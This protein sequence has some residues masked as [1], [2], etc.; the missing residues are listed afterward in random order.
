MRIRP[1]TAPR[2]NAPQGR[3]MVKH[4]AAALG[5]TGCGG[6]GK[7]LRPMRFTFI[8]AADLHVDSPLA[9]LGAK[10]RAVA[11]RFAHAGRK[12]VENL[13]AR[14]LE[15]KAAFLIIAGDLFDGDWRD[16]S[17]GHFLARALGPLHRADIPVFIQRGNH[18][19]ASKIA[20][21][22]PFAPSVR[23]F[24]DAAPQTFLL[25]H[26]GVALHGRSFG[27]RELP[28]DFV[29]T[30]P[31]AQAH[32]LNIGVLHTSLSGDRGHDPYAPASIADLRA[33]GYDYWAL[34]HVHAG[35]ILD[36]DPWVV[37]PGNLQGR[38]VRETGA[39][40][41]VRVVVEN[42]RI[43]EA[44]HFACDAAR[45]ANETLDVSGCADEADIAAA[46]EALF[47]HAAREAE[48]RP[49]ALRLRLSGV[50]P[51]H[52][53]LTAGRERLE[54][55][56]RFAAARHADDFW[57]ERLRLATRAPQ[58]RPAAGADAL[59]VARLLAEAAA[60]P[61]FA[62]E[63]AALT[64]ALVDKAPR[65]RDELSV[66]SREDWAAE[67]RDLLIGALETGDAP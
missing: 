25:D 41:A 38:S 35:E 6:C 39:K 55:D 56:L 30:Y 59:D 10:D 50:T 57:I 27:P 14:T 51:L 22:L 20:R 48:G 4:R 3:R 46:A 64:A 60:E 18:D 45:W 15:E 31:Q 2:V 63:I 44:T 43:R 5:L 1:Y 65:L 66:L 32:M 36:R 62:A 28:T 12:A 37:Y 17:T 11:E 13:V 67:A 49:L 40:G 61:D 8:H 9:A 53:R 42:G 7:A 34:G 23:V 24:D 58:T 52:A 19:A 21:D 16:V 26:L 29:S 33:F 54:D 47:A